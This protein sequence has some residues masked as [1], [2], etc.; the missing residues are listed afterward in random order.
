MIDINNL[1]NILRGDYAQY[2]RPLVIKDKCDL[3]GN[4]KELNF[5]H[6]L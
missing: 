1:K 6:L 4:D 2:I 5:L 3:C